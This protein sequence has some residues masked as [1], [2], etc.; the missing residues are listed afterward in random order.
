MLVGAHHPLDYPAAAGRRDRVDQDAPVDRRRAELRGTPLAREER[1]RRRRRR[2]GDVADVDAIPSPGRGAVGKPGVRDGDS[3]GARGIDLSDRGEAVSIEELDRVSRHRGDE[4]SAD[5]GVLA[6][7]RHL[8]ASAADHR[9]ASEPLEEQRVCRGGRIG[10]V[11]DLGSLGSGASRRDHQGDRDEQQRG[12]V[13]AAQAHVDAVALAHQLGRPDAPIAARQ[14]RQDHDRDRPADAE[15]SAE[16]QAEGR[17]A[18][19]EAD[20]GQ[21]PD[22]EGEDEGREA[23]A[24]QDAVEGGGER[25]RHHAA[26]VLRELAADLRHDPV[27]LAPRVLRR[28]ARSPAATT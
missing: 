18:D 21:R 25:H 10:G 22:P 12:G 16:E 14:R 2:V 26:P 23:E 4:A 6:G 17:I 5:S 1:R 3:V 19:G 28:A 9:R 8:R 27:S 20:P 7:E 24:E 11:R 13:T 15:G